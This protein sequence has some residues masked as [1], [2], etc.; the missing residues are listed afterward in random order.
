MSEQTPPAAWLLPGRTLPVS[1]PTADEL[2]LARLEEGLAEVGFA[3]VP[4]R[5]GRR[6]DT[7]RIVSGGWR[8][9]LLG[10][11]LTPRVAYLA[12]R[13]RP[14][15][16]LTNTAIT[17]PTFAAIKLVLGRRVHAVANVVGIQSVELD[18]I[19]PGR[20]R[21]ALY[22]PILRLLEALLIRSADLVLTVNDIHGDVVRR[23]FPHAKVVTLRDCADPALADTRPAD[24]AD[25][26]VPRDALAVGFVG[27]L[28]YDRLKPV[29]EAWEQVV[30]DDGSALAL[31]VV[32]DGP[33]LRRYARMAAGRGWLWESVFFLGARPR[34]EAVAVMAACD[35]TYSECW[36]E[37]GF[38]SKLY[39]YMALG[40]PMVV[41]GKP[42]MREVVEDGRE[43]RFFTS[44]GELAEALRDLAADPGLRATMGRQA[45]ETL[46]AGHTL[47]HRRRQFAELLAPVAPAG[48]GPVTVDRPRG[49]P[50]TPLPPARELPER[51]SVV[52][53]VLNAGDVFRRTLEGIGSQRYG[54]EW[55]VLIVDNG[56]SDGSLEIAESWASAQPAAR[57]L[58][59]PESHNAGYARNRGAAA[60]TGDFLAFCDA[61]DMP[62]EDWLGELVR[63]GTRSDLVGGRRYVPGERDPLRASW[64]DPPSELGLP[65]GHGFLRFATGGNLGIWSE[66]F[67]RI[68]GFEEAFVNGE[69]I[70]LSWRAQLAGYRLAFAPHATTEVTPRRELRSLARQQYQWGA[71][72]GQLYRRYGPAGMP[73]SSP[74]DAG[75]TW[76]RLL[77]TLPVAIASPG[78][79]GRWLATAALRSGRLTASLRS[80]AAF[81]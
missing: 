63:A 57:V 73:R 15:L 26:G 27:S 68:G 10:L 44:P 45:R 54:G 28:A 8:A 31:V 71:C 1:A 12:W 39:E 3:P 53:P 47:D 69:D 74:L 65:T 76:T 20:L 48:R 5:A 80:R 72:S 33:D 2:I 52:V 24:R 21:K 17:A 58:R 56:S 43:A 30:R 6:G 64:V 40:K 16:V 51:V 32:G 78:R 41:E 60:A 34:P 70:D 79:R 36:S 37:L 9:A 23:R 81:L 46:L 67:E 7:R 77:L 66:V 75:L 42:Q 25:L 18:Q 59:A 61:D 62:L 29:F 55:E 35:I 38:P 11:V 4:F 14:R 22:R 19:T 49:E 50:S 13:E